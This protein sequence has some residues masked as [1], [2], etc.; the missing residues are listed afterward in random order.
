MLIRIEE[1]KKRTQKG[2]LDTFKIAKHSWSKAHNI[3]Y[4]TVTYC[5]DIGHR[6]IKEAAA[7]V[8]I[9]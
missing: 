7:F 4:V 6:K 1:H 5:S 9:K 3:Q 2:E 8:T